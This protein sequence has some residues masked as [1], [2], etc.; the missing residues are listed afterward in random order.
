MGAAK[1]GRRMP[2]MP[3]TRSA[4]I[5]VANGFRNS[6]K[7]GFTPAA[8]RPPIS[9]RTASAAAGYAMRFGPLIAIG[10]RHISGLFFSLIRH[11]ATRSGG[12]DRLALHV[13]SAY[14]MPV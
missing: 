9:A 6:L 12:G 13:R 7:R 14:S 11:A 8:P 1:Q 3:E 5:R 10:K 4:T 2:L